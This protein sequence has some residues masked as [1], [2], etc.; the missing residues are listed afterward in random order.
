MA[1]S[2]AAAARAPEELTADEAVAAQGGTSILWPDAVNFT[3]CM[4][5]FWL[6]T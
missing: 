3:L 1:P 6:L 5:A 4:G 2:L